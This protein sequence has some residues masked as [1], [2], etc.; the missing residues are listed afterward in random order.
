[1]AKICHVIPNANNGKPSILFGELIKL[2][3]MT[4]D[5]A[6]SIYKKSFSPKFLETLTEE[7][8]D[9]NGEPLLGALQL[10]EVIEKSTKEE[11]VEQ[12]ILEDNSYI[13]KAGREIFKVQGD[14]TRT[15]VQ[16][17]IK[18]DELV[19][20]GLAQPY[21][22]TTDQYIL[23][24]KTS[25][26]NRTAS[27]TLNDKL[28]S[29]LSNYGIRVE[30]VDNMKERVGVDANG[31]A[32]IFEKLILISKGKEKID[33]LPEEVA[34]FAVE[35]LGERS[36]LVSRLLDLIEDTTIYNT[37]FDEYKDIYVDLKGQPNIERIK[38]EAVG[39]AIAEKIINNTDY[40][41]PRGFFK[42]LKMFWDRF[43]SY[44]KKMN[45]Q[46]YLDEVD[47]ITDWIA[48]DILANRIEG[49]E[50][51]L[52]TPETYFQG[53]TKTIAEKQEEFLKK[54]I[55][56]LESRAKK[57]GKLAGKEEDAKEMRAQVDKMK[58]LLD[59]NK[60][61]QGVSAFINKVESEL[62]PLQ[63]YMERYKEGTLQSELS[64]RKVQ[65][66][67][68]FIAA[69]DTL[70]SEVIGMIDFDPILRDKMSGAL[71]KAKSIKGDIDELNTFYKKA[72]RE[73]ATAAVIRAN[74]GRL[75]NVDEDIFNN[76]ASKDTN[77]LRR[78]V[79]SMKNATDPVLK[80]I[81]DSVKKVKNNVYKYT[82]DRGRELVLAQQKLDKAGIKDMGM[83]FEKDKKGNKTG[84]IVSQYK[85]GEYYSNLDKFK[86]DLAKSF[87]AENYTEL[88]LEGFNEMQK[89]AFRKAWAEYLET[90]SVE[91]YKNPDWLKVRNNSVAYDYYKKIME[92]K[93]I[94]DAK[95]PIS[96]SDRQ[97]YLAPQIRK[98]T[99]ERL[100]GRDGNVWTNIKEVISENFKIT[101]DDIDYNPSE[102]ITDVTGK[103]IKFVPVHFTRKMENI[104]NLSEDLTSMMIAYTGM[105]ENYR[106]TYDIIP[107]MELIREELG[108]R[109][110]IGDKHVKSGLQS[111]T[112]AMVTDFMDRNLYGNNKKKDQVV[113]IGNKVVNYGKFLDMVNSYVRRNNLAF[114]TFATTA[115]YTTGSIFSKVEDL[116]GQYTTN[117]SKL[118]AEKEF[119]K[120]LP[121][122]IAQIGKKRPTN[123]MHLL[124]MR[125]GFIRDNFD[126]LNVNTRGGREMKN[127]FFSTYQMV[128]YRVKGK[129]ALAIMDNMR[130]VNGEWMT[131]DQ[132]KRANGDLGKSE[133]N[134]KWKE[135]KGKSFYNAH[136]VIDGELV[137]KK[138][139]KDTITSE[140]ENNIK[141]RIEHIGNR[142]DGML[143]DLDRGAIYQSVWGRLIM[144]H[145]G[146]LVK[147]AEDR[148]KVGGMNLDTGEMEEGYYRTIGNVVALP[149]VQMF[150]EL[151]ST[152][153]LNLKPY[154]ENFKNLDDHQKKNV[155]RAVFEIASLTMIWAL[156]KALENVV[157]D[158][159]DDYL[160]NFALYSLYRTKL[161]VGAFYNPTEIPKLLKSPAAGINQLES[162]TDAFGLLFTYDEEKGGWGPLQEIERGRYGG[163]T[164][165][166][167]LLI[168]RSFAKNFYEAQFPKEKLKYIKQF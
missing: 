41:A 4:R 112:Y 34:H 141:N 2:D 71:E 21:G 126:D 140:L 109:S 58:A 93:E 43:M 15:R 136:E 160:T 162:I 74:N 24:S 32:L 105:A 63:N 36:P 10:P 33:T 78:W 104:E 115:S 107:E 125:N 133:I 150:G 79:G 3:G 44:F 158:D 145:R 22:T 47:V 18:M 164:R 113:K 85:L 46:T 30:H 57:L 14:N 51:H 19:Q 129:V 52:I 56:N 143:S 122:V 89:K 138:E 50:E 83:F 27:E 62:G 29:F 103:Q 149:L 155:K 82:F 156:I 60:I 134:S 45:Y 8:L 96:G 118:F 151:I 94:E 48:D 131:K 12:G 147:G 154:I 87:G 65:N 20:K 70:M 61:K 95:V 16:N 86:Q 25:K 42:T 161:E 35:L 5:R 28:H 75:D 152:R 73:T 88:N 66:M 137:V 106:Q 37:T 92:A 167:K 102:P 77:I 168:Q 127:I 90:N 40:K 165:S 76:S 26:D 139:F 68:D 166:E 54:A 124:F 116:V 84:Y 49:K 80:L 69:Y 1:M 72:R 121:N 100:R 99:L 135:V 6:I 142:A 7:Q 101:E 132:F 110:I 91:N 17:R 81:Y 148:F 9:S 144:T 128:D 64:T 97:K 120:Q 146:W 13:D 130:L 153:K 11:L 123:K 59:K 111:N 31:A 38:K 39:K 114:N 117:E 53:P 98:D 23:L 67:G 157:G 108:E 119:D 163:M 159:E 55:K